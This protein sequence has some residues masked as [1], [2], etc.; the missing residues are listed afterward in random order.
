[1]GVTV[2][3]LP[4]SLEH[5]VAHFQSL[6]IGLYPLVADEWSVG[7]SGFKAVQY[8]ACAVPTVAS[9]VGVTSDMIR[10]GDNGFLAADDATWVERLTQL[11]D[12]PA[13]RKRLGAAGRADALASWSLAVQAP[14]FVDIVRNAMEAR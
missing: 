4:W 3:Q 2:E 1:P 13:L 6:D 11:I 12:E 9:P 8:M 14:R 7:K 5:E 10:D